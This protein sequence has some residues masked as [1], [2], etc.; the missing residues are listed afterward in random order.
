MPIGSARQLPDGSAALIAGVLTTDLGALETGHTAFIEDETGGI[1]LYLDAPVVAAL[2]VGT[3]VTVAGTIDERYGQRTLRTSE[4]AVVVGGSTATLEAATA[5]TGSATEGLEGRRIVVHGAMV[6]SADALADGTAVSIDDGSGPVRVIVTPAALGGRSLVAGSIVTA[7]GP[8]GQ[9]DSSGTGTSGY[10]LYVTSAGDLSVEAE[11]TPSPTATASP[12]PA[13]TP[14][15]TTSEPP[16]PSPTPSP[17]PSTPTP[18]PSP[19]DATLTIAAVRGLPVGTVVATRG[20]VTAEPGRLG[21]PPLFAI[22]DATGGI[23]VKLPSDVSGLARG[24]VVDV[25]GTLVDPY[26]QLEIRPA[27]GGLVV[28]GTSAIPDPMMLPP[29]GPDEHSEGRLV[30]LDGVVVARPAKATSGDLGLTI[31]TSNAPASECWRTHP[32]A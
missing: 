30:R 19:S 8:L 7:T 27:T 4:A 14:T 18:T 16:A 6:G 12:T 11:P 13:P 22:G 28:G 32:A 25:R 3:D 31:E 23:V 20:V 2:P 9:R 5:S 26:G 24:R 1:A 21:T 17:S 15:P 10:R 29:T